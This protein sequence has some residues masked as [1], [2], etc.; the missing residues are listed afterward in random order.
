MALDDTVKAIHKTFGKESLMNLKTGGV[1]AKDFI[2]SGSLTLD[3]AL[4]GGIVRG[5]VVELFG[6]E[7][8]GKTTLAIH[9][10]VE[11]QK[12]GTAVFVDIEH[13]FDAKYSENIGLDLDNFLFSQPES[14][15]QAFEIVEALASCEEVSIIV[16]DSVASLS[17]R[18]E[19]EGDSGSSQM[20]LIAR[21]MGQHLRKVTP[22]ASRNKTTLLY[23]N[24]I[25]MKLGV[26]F[27]CFHYN[28]RVLLEDGK[29]KKIGKIVNQ[30]IPAKVLSY[31]KETNL[32]EAR[33]IINWH[34]NKK[35]KKFI[36]IVVNKPYGN[37]RCNLPIGDNHIIF[38]PNGEKYATDL[39][40]GDKV[41]VKSIRYL[42]K[43]QKDLAIGTFLG[44][45]SLR[46]QKR[47]KETNMV[48]LRMGHGI[49]Q[50][51]Y[52]LWKI[53][54]L[55]KEFVGSLY[56]D[57]E[58]RTRFD[59]KKTSELAIFKKYKKGSALIKVDDFLLS[60]ISE[61]SIAIWYLDDGYFAS[62]NCKKWGNGRSVIFMK[63]LSIKD[64]EKIIKKFE[65]MGLTHLSCNKNGIWINS[66]GNMNFHK[67]IAP[68]VPKCM[69]YKIHSK[70]RYL[71]E[72]Y[73]ASVKNEVKEILLPMS[74]IKIYEKPSSKSTY[75]FDIEVEKNN[76]YF[77]DGILV[78]NSPETT[79]GGNALKYQASI[80]LDIRRIKTLKEGDLPIGIKSRV[81][82]VKNKTGPPLRTAE[83]NIMYGKG[84]DKEVE[85]FDICLEKGIITKSGSWFSYGETKLGHGQLKSIEYLESNP[86]IKKQ[87]M[88]KLC[89]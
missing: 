69:S 86:E 59:S 44:D 3:Q 29:T 52:C 63:K 20:G 81:R 37:G 8:S 77:V 33:K 26:L 1:L 17:P 89:L 30:K 82:V 19:I 7:S 60:N 48:S 87:I 54:Q 24:Q 15:E 43:D 36:Q 67:K 62:Q 61:R 12:H 73:K 28:A 58:N 22:L 18:A 2:S 76:N 80:R 13:S 27:G 34:N 4:S 6:S 49:K 65:G 16:I 74:I 47:T 55:P 39:K 51:D 35:A 32:I 53:K 64:K 14:A 40:V 41:Y 79:P 10:M 46:L 66:A 68:Y 84:I 50:E 11:A 88:E 56:K 57:N 25:R 45:G 9:A 72:T 70:L 38:T 31:N 78:H 23:V 75:K 42:N 85:L 21:L 5:R 71:C 83:F